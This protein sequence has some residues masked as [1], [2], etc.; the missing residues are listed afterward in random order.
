VTDDQGCIGTASISVSESVQIGLTTTHT[1]AQCG[2]IP[3]GTVS[4]Q[5]NGGTPPYSYLWNDPAAQTTSTA[6]GLPAGTYTVT[7]TDA[8]GCTVVRSETVQSPMATQITVTSTN[9]SC[10]GGNNGSVSVSVVNANPNNFTYKWN[11]PAGSTTQSVAGLPAGNYSITVTD[12]DGCSVTGSTSVT[13]PPALNLTIQVDSASCA[14]GMDGAATAN[15]SGGTPSAGGSYNYTWNAPGNP[16]SANLTNILPGNYTLTVTDANGCT[17]VG[18]ASIGAPPKL[19]LAGT[20]TPATCQSAPNGSAMVTAS[21][22]TPPYNYQWDDPD[23]QTT[24]SISNVLPGI[25]MLFVTDAKGCTATINVTVAFVPS[26]SIQTS[27]QD[28]TCNGLN[29]GSASVTVSGNPIGNVTYLW[30]NPAASTTPTISNL[31]PGIYTVTVTDAMGCFQTATAAVFEPAL[32][33]LSISKTNVYC[34]FDSNGSANAVVSGGV[35]PYSYA[36]SGGQTTSSISNLAKGTYSLTVTD[37]NGCTKAASTVIISTSTL[38]SITSSVAAKCFGS[39]DGSAS[40]V[41][42]GGVPPYTYIWSN[43]A[44]GSTANNLAAGTYVVTITDSDG[45]WLTDTAVV[46]QPATLNC[47]TELVSPITTFGGSDGSA[48]VLPGGGAAPYSFMWSNGA[49]TQ[50][51]TNLNAANYSVTLTDGNGCTCVSHINMKNPSKIGNFIWNDLDQDGIQDAG[52]PGLKDVSVT[53]EGT[54]GAGV[55]VNLATTSDANGNYAFDGLKEGFY[56]LTF[57]LLP[58]SLFSPQNIGDDN[59]DSDVDPATGSTGFFALGPSYN[60]AHWDAGMIVLDEKI[61]LGD[62]VWHDT[63]HNGIQDAGESGVEGV[64]IKLLSSPGNTLLATR[65]TN[66]LG[67]YLFEDVMPGNYVIEF[68]VPSLPAGFVI[69]PQYQGTSDALDS[70]PNPVNGRT[71]VITVFPF[72]LDN[73]TIDCG[74]FKECDNVTDGGLIG[75][76]ED[77]CGIG[78]DPAPIV[79]VA[80]P[81]G[82]FGTLEYLWMYSY[83]PVWNGPGD[84]NWTP[85]PNSNSPTYDPGPVGQ[86]TYYIR[87]VRRQGCNDYIGESNIVAKKVTPYALTQIIDAPDE[88]CVE[89]GG[90]FEA[91]IAGGGA[92]YFWQF[93]ADAVPQT[94]NTRV[95]DPVYWTTP[96]VKTVSLTV[97][98]FGCAFTVTRNVTVTNCTSPL[99][100]INDLAATMHDGKVTLNW[101]VTG[102][103]KNAVFFVQRSENAVDFQTLAVVGGTGGSWFSEYSLVDENPKLGDN[104][105]RI[106]FRLL[107]DEPI[108]GYSEV[109]KVY[110]EPDGTGIVQV[111]PNPT[112]GNVTVELLKPNEQ[113]VEIEVFNPLGKVMLRKEFPG[114]TE[115]I[116]L[117]LS[118]FSLGFYLIKIKQKGFREQVRR[119]IKGE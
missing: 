3:D 10:N 86:T 106:K 5:V 40:A 20:A 76:D 75:Y 88:L 6:T 23:G 25:Y 74:I 115:K 92:T 114:N 47:T 93:G 35:T 42:S 81:T 49:S 100:V 83:V 98:R 99:M 104:H 54:T 15:V 18:S 1:D 71:D 13:Q 67:N 44:A 103:T 19:T 90:R 59:L 62:R 85:I 77:L 91:A 55:A 60:A 87:C 34:A 73:L 33:S 89:E 105:Y 107:A 7:V 24:P 65:T 37:A 56:K 61:D 29:N 102:D 16:T 53:L 22:G 70:N 43:G 108:E 2:N 27:S 30:N 28:I 116:D 101:Q 82:G 111:Y 68:S 48:K 8:N 69:A 52:E 72:T 84:P 17:V 14:G 79:N 45:C 119:V 26:Y 78:A 39:A 32:L 41:G 50:T 109:T 11:D 117:D 31:S 38:S 94:A 64:F 51:A 110:C 63:N 118:Q 112:S 96:G 21:G 4:A 66:L 36:W 95:V 80:S 9:V 58:N 57:K 113:P 97:T 46:A 12:L